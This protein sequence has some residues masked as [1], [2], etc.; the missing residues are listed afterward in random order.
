MPLIFIN[1]SVAL[2]ILI[3]WHLLATGVLNIVKMLQMLHA[4]VQGN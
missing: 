1:L 4:F 2:H 3:S